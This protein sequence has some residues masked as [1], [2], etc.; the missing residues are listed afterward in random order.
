MLL[1]VFVRML[2]IETAEKRSTFLYA[3]L[4]W[5]FITKHISY[6]VFSLCD[7][8]SYLHPFLFLSHMQLAAAIRSLCN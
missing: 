6:D 8:L 3:A 2:L 4:Q 5:T 1:F 7:S